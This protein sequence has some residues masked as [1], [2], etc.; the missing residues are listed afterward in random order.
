MLFKNIAYDVNAVLERDPAARS[1][2]EVFLMYPGIQAVMWHRL[3]QSI[4]LHSQKQLRH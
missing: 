2:A 3:A 1:K 4:T